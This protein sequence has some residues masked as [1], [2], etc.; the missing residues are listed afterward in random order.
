MSLPSLRLGRLFGDLPPCEFEPALLQAISA[1][2][3]PLAIR[4]APATLD[5]DNPKIP[6][7]FAVLARLVEHDASYH[8]L[9]VENGRRGTAPRLALDGMY[10]DGPLAMPCFYDGARLL[11]GTADNPSADLARNRIGMALIPDPR[12]DA[13]VMLAQLHLAFV[14]F[15]NVVVDDMSAS[16]VP[17][18]ILFARAARQVR[19]H[20][21]WLLLHEFLPMLIGDDH[22]DRLRRQGPKFYRRDLDPRLPAEFAAAAIRYHLSQFGDAVKLNAE[23][24]CRPF[25]SQEC[26]FRPIAAASRIDWLHFVDMPR[27]DRPQSSK[28]VDGYLN[29]SLLSTASTG[30]VI[31]TL[32]LGNACQLPSGQAIARQIGTTPLQN[33]DF[34]LADLLDTGEGTPLWLYVLKE[35]E[36]IQD[37]M[38]LGPVGA[39]IV[40]DLVVDLIQRDPAS[41][42]NIEPRWQPSYGVMGS[43]QFADLLVASDYYTPPDLVAGRA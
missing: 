34:G 2:D 3:G 21:Q 6:L 18:D 5:L 33:D 12:D 13:D 43:C 10:G 14:K 9:P 11:M 35:A 8:A 39:A 27:S 22:A 19:W 16:G 20:Y 37:G 36:V 17:P 24:M 7:G 40:G 29:G 30:H 32:L 31:D 41:Y 23:S 38:R 4:H 42:T 25:D 28:R 26:G 15:H 1:R